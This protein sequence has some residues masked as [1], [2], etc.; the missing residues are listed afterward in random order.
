VRVLPVGVDA[1]L[2]EVEDASAARDLAS[3]ARTRLPDVTEIVAG[4]RTVLLDGVTDPVAVEARLAG[5][6][7]TP[8]DVVSRRV[9]LPTAYDG[10]DLDE[11]A[12]RWGMTSAEAALTHASVEYTVSFCGFSPGFAYC[13]GLPEE[14]WVPRR[15]DPRPRVEAGAIGL[16]GEFTGV[17]PSASPG[18]WRLV[19]RTSAALWDTDRDEPALLTPGTRVRFVA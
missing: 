12:R 17:Y 15:D 18:G 19:G 3:F 6:V 9:D 14:L 13:T 1:L 10:P 16:A 2:V 4:A 7:P 11:V 8:A 5:W